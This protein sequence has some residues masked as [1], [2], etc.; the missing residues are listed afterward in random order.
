[1]SYA[2]KGILF[3]FESTKEVE[4]TKIDDLFSTMRD[5]DDENISFALVKPQYLREYAF[6][7]PLDVKAL[8]DIQEDSTVSVYNIVIIQKPLENSVVNFLAPI[9]INHDNNTL[10]QAVLDPKKYP[11]FGMAEPIKSFIQN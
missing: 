6:D 7:L 5:M 11:D 3:G 2:V 4:I 8:L 1:M 9:I 10:A